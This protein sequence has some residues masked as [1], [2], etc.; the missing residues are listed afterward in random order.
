[1]NASEDAWTPFLTD[2]G[3]TLCLFD[4]K[5]TVYRYAMP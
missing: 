4:G 3:K 1:M 5:H 2:G